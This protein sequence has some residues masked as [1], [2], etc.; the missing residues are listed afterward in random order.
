MLAIWAW[1]HSNLTGVFWLANGKNGKSHVAVTIPLFLS[2]AFLSF[3]LCKC[4]R[5][6]SKMFVV[7]GG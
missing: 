7:E 5:T 2:Y 3:E 6:F 1:E 4:L